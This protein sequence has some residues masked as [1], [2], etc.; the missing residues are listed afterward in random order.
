MGR[1]TYARR[2]E[3]LLVFGGRDKRVSQEEAGY[4]ELVDATKDATCEKVKGQISSERGCCNL[5]QPTFD[6]VTQFKCG[7]CEYIKAAK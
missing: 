3:G 7:T 2:K 1:I 4:M 5:F 6:G